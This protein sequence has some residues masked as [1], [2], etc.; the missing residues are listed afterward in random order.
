MSLPKLMELRLH[1][2]KLKKIVTNGFMNVPALKI[3]FLQYNQ[4]DSLEPGTLQIF[5]ELQL[6]DLGRNVLYKVVEMDHFDIFSDLL[7]FPQIPSF[8]DMTALQ[9][10]RL[11]HNRIQ[12]IDTLTFSA[13]PLLQKII[14]NNNQIETIARNSF[15][16]LDALGTL[17]LSNNSLSV[18][19][20]YNNSIFDLSQI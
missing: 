17:V 4:L 16:S 18:I 13:N 11:H 1:S 6:I 2:N 20:G 14:L 8:K 5:K 19:G 3:L 12:T 7:P 9:E 10:V 15:D